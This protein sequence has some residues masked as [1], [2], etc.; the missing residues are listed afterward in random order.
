MPPGVVFWI[1]RSSGAQ[2]ALGRPALRLRRATRSSECAQ[3]SR[4][5]RALAADRGLVRAC[6]SSRR[7]SSR[8]STTRRRAKKLLAEAGYRRASTAGDLTPFRVLLAGRGVGTIFRKSIRTRMRTMER[9]A[10]LTAWR[11]HKIK[12]VIMGSARRRQRATRIEVYVT[13]SGIYARAWSRRSRI[14]TRV[15]ARAGSKEARG[16]AAPD[17][18]DHV[19][20]GHARAIYELAFLWARVAVDE[21]ASTTSRAF[22]TRRRTRISS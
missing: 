14:S 18:A 22:R 12:G 4:D 9:A 2:V 5:A 17:P 6:W 1:C 20:P 8:P 3:S 13:K 15:R 11:E 21:R 7:R 10:F 16:D 19:R